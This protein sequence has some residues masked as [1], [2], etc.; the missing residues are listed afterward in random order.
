MQDNYPPGMTTADHAYLDE[1][2][3][4]CE[5]DQGFSIIGLE[6]LD[7]IKGE[8]SIRIRCEIC[9]QEGYAVYKLLKD[10]EGKIEPETEW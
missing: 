6:E 3:P 7:D 9:N 4:P 8:V 2:Y 1:D 5:H 10:S